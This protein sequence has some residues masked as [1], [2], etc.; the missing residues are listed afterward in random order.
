MPMLSLE[1][2]L[3]TALLER[4]SDIHLTVGVPPILRI[5]GKLLHLGNGNL[6]NEVTP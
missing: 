5:N 4:A 2:I 6:T 1:K 3:E